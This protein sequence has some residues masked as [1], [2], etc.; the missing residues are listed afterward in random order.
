MKLLR[1]AIDDT[2]RFLTE[3]I[4]LIYVVI[5]DGG[6]KRAVVT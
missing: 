3:I 1:E 5:F 6:Y 4:L 2:K